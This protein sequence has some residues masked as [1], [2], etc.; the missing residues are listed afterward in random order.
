M[1]PGSAA[2]PL[3]RS[4]RLLEKK[5]TLTVQD[6]ADV[7]EEDSNVDRIPEPP[8]KRRR[9][10]ASKV[11]NQVA[12]QDTTSRGRRK[13]LSKL[14]DMPLD[15]LYEVFSHLHP[16]DLLRLA[17]TTKAFRRLLLSRSSITIWRESLASVPGL[18]ECPPDL[19]EP[20]YTNLLFDPHCHFCVK[21]RVM[22]VMWACRLRC[23]KSCLKDNFIELVDI[24]RTI[25]PPS[26]LKP[27][28]ML[29]AE[30]INNRLLF[31]KFKFDELLERIAECE[32]DEEKLKALEEQRIQL[33]IDQEKS[34]EMLED[35]QDEAK[36]DRYIDKLQLRLR[37]QH[38]IFA[39]LC[40]LGYAL[41]L[42]AMTPEMFDHFL[43]HPSVKQPKE[44]TDR[45]WNNIKESMVAFAESARADRLMRKH[46]EEYINRLE[47]IRDAVSDYL[48]Q[49]PLWENLP[50]VADF[51]WYT[52]FKDIIM[53]RERGVFFGKAALPPETL[54]PAL[55]KF[56]R[57]W[58]LDMRRRLYEMIPVAA[59]PVEAERVIKRVKEEFVNN[60]GSSA[61]TTEA[62]K[63]EKYKEQEQILIALSLATTW[64]R[65]GH[66]ACLLDYP[67]VQAHRCLK[68][69][70]A[71]K[72]DR[73]TDADDRANAYNIVLKEFPWNYTGDKVSYDEEARAAAEKVVRAYGR[74]PKKTEAFDI[75]IYSPRFAC[76]ECSRDGRVYV[77]PWRVAVA[78][79]SDHRGKDVKITL[80]NDRDRDYAQ[81]RERDYMKAYFSDVYKIWGCVRC[82]G[83]AMPLRDVLE[84]CISEHD[85][86]YPGEEEDWDLHPDAETSL[87]VPAQ[88]MPYPEAAL[89]TPIQH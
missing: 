64:F 12:R 37:R 40:A 72:V 73:K 51:S 87:G 69:G 42:Q 83:D 23:C 81:D 31:P 14:P 85:I 3:R 62:A 76:G 89:T 88:A 38:Q 70:P 48:S 20:S 22:T 50:S 66:C 52:P 11:S 18:P 28:A 9:K 27:G 49:Y 77:M 6:D 36:H 34:A 56:V 10:N 84:H 57:Q 82:R 32:G 43:D 1:S 74:D 67:R 46:A 35:W 41:D 25:G 45:I 13:S 5:S 17:R 44:L 30:Q 24:F 39:R 4:S 79:L 53:N 60:E 61:E 80:L 78:H 59:R 86:Q 75:D 8:P 26:W 54:N 47:L 71:I 33:V 19:T 15:I 68:T 63:D 21:A 7:T 2:G 58:Q 55:D 65:C 29:P 16:Y